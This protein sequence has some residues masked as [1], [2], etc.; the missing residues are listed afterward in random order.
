MLHRLSIPVTA[1][2][3]VTSLLAGRL[4]AAV[5]T[6]DRSIVE[7]TPG[8]VAFWTFAEEPGHPRVSTGTREKHPLEE[9]GGPIA[10]VEGGP[11]SG[12]SAELNG[13]RYFRIPYA[14]TG[15]LNISDT[16]AQVSM[17]VVVRLVDLKQSRTIAGMW[18]E[19]KGAND[20]SG[21]RQY[22]LL[23]NMPAYGGPRQLTPHISSEGGV[24][25]RAD[26]SAFPWCADYAATKREVP[27]ETWCTLG[28]TYD[29]RFIRAYINGV[30]DA[31]A[32]DPVKD[33]RTDR[34]FTAEGPGGKDRGMNPYYH[35]RGI[36]RYDPAR[37]AKTKPGGG[38]DFTVGARYAV[39]TML[40]EATIGRFGGLAVFNRALSDEEMSKLHEAARVGALNIP[41]PYLGRIAPRAASRIA[42]S[43]WSI[44]GETLDRDFAVYANYKRFLGPLGAKRIR[45]QAGWAKC[46]QRP[47]VYDWAWLDE[48]VNDALAQGVQPWLETSYGNTNYPGGGGTGLGGGLPSSPEA[49]AAWDNW[50]RALVRRYQ[51]RVK[52]WEVWNEPD[53]G[54]DA[55]AEAY[56]EFFIR[57]AEIIRAEQPAARIWAL[58]LAGKMAYAETFLSRMKEKGKLNLMDAVTV[59]GYPKNPDDTTT[60]DRMRTL[61]AKHGCAIPVI[62]GET[63]APSTSNTFGALRGHSWTELTQAKWNLRRMLAHHAKDVPFNLFTLMELHYTTGLN[64]KGLLKANA[65]KT[66][67]CAKPAYSAAQNVFAVFDD[68]L[69]RVAEYP[70]T[71]GVTNTLALHAWHQRN[72]RQQVV[73]LWFSGDVP[74]DST[75]TV[76][77]DFALRKGEF[78]E[79]VY[80]DLR[81]GDVHRIPKANWSRDENGVTFRQIPVYDSPVLIAELS[82]LPIERAREVTP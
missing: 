53:L 11:F 8:L 70:F 67:A 72:T 7:Q 62:Q 55:P 71:P 66:A 52:E 48:V 33:R 56:A 69:S 32:L 5:P 60:V 28:F 31:R 81:T 1:L 42:A 74:A 26:G 6:G 79:P 64:T 63:G 21:T 47:G 61:L 25:R 41:L 59:H 19:G 24:T 82:A 16:N 49:L 44:G 35:G 75:A 3:A 27:E 20:D 54:K 23:M 30:L 65:D 38:S 51:D 80:A 37:H 45:L 78:T 14:E 34:Y 58:G 39:G 57:T 76:G 10:R 2:L 77:V 50:L 73:A 29:G 4:G 46:E 22:A 9:V 15:G 18:S 40:G 36:F 17:F 12:Y 43:S 13:K 68:T